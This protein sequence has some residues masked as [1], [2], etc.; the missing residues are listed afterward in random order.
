MPAKIMLSSTI[1]LLVIASFAQPAA[2]GGLK[3]VASVPMPCE[4]RGERIS[5]LGNQVAVWCSDHTVRLVDVHSGT[6]ARSFGP[7]P[8]VSSG[9]YSRDGRWFAVGFG[10]GTVE[11][12]PTS[13]AAGGKRWKSDTRGI[14]ALEF[15]PDSS[16]IVVAASDRPGQVW[17]LRGTPKPVATLHSDFAGLIACSFSPDGKLLV[18]ADGDTAI[19]FYDAA[20]WKMLHEYRGLTLETFAVAFTTDGKRAL[21]GGPDDHI[22]VLDPATGAELHKLAKDADVVELIRTFGTDGQAMINYFDVD[23]RKPDHRSIWNV[24]T[25][26][27]VPLTADHPLTGSGIVGGKLW[28]SSSNGKVLDIWVYE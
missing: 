6:T 27:S 11:V 3:P 21:I 24:N 15:L 5:P 18:T 4:F 20:T 14:G 22:T 12:V 1:L 13:G 26:Q 16:G 2:S 19:R 28:V 25:A 7:E 8:W 17:D 10:D 9:Y 23:G